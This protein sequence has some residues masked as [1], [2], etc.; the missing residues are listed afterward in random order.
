MG[1]VGE[2]LKEMSETASEF[3]IQN[4]GDELKGHEMC[5]GLSISLPNYTYMYPCA[6]LI[7]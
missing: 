1:N 5:F 4:D 6:L 3:T 2:T 7:D